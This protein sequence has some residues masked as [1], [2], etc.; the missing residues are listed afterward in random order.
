MSPDIRIAAPHCYTYGTESPIHSGFVGRPPAT[1][2]K[3]VPINRNLNKIKMK[4]FISHYIVPAILLVAN[5]CSSSYSGKTY[6]DPNSSKYIKFLNSNT[7]EWQWLDRFRPEEF[8]YTIEGNKIRT[9]RKF[10]GQIT[11]IEII[12]NEE[13][14]DESGNIYFLQ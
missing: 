8:E 3:R 9:V 11:Y 1:L 4:K 6:Q 13:L 12:G 10:L 7:I 14:K 5:S 2:E